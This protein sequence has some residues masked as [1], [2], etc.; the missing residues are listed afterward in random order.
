MQSTHY[1]NTCHLL[2]FPAL[3]KSF[4]HLVLDIEPRWL[5]SDGY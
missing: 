3:A 1:Y 2:D 4:P 5:H